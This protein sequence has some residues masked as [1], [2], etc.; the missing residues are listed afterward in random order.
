[1]IVQPAAF[2]ILV[3]VFAGMPQDAAAA[4]PE[5]AWN[6]DGLATVQI[7]RCG[8]AFCG[9][10]LGLT[11][12]EATHRPYLDRHNQNESQRQR[13]LCGVTIMGGLRPAGADEWAG[14]WFYNPNDGATYKLSA[15][16]TA[17]DILVARVFVGI[18]IFG[19]SKSAYRLPAGKVVGSC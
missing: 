15:E 11:P 6:I 4:S 9:R 10:V 19:K 18:E 12:H 1:L 7:F 8:D 14:G 16:L 2:L 5:G 13:P 3:G 17:P